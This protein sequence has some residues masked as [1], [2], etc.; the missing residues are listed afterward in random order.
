MQ[1]TERIQ[2]V[3]I[4]RTYITLRKVRHL[5]VSG[6]YHGL[7][8]L[9]ERKKTALKMLLRR[10]EP[11]WN[12]RK[13]KATGVLTSMINPQIHDADEPFR[14]K[15]VQGTKAIYETTVLSPPPSE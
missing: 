15:G 3:W 1:M 12:R 14:A 4:W 10:S 11:L 7:I 2:A 5:F 13:R 9:Q 8:V 6:A